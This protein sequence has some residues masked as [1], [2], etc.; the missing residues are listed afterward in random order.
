MLH[1]SSMEKERPISIPLPLGSLDDSEKEVA[2]HDS[3]SSRRPRTPSMILRNSP[4]FP[5]D[6]DTSENSIPR[7]DSSVLLTAEVIGTAEEDTLSPL[8]DE[9]QT[10]RIRPSDGSIHE[11]VVDLIGSEER[12]VSSLKILLGSLLNP[13]LTISLPQIT[14]NSLRELIH[15]IEVILQYNQFFLSSLRE[16]FFKDPTKPNV[17]PAFLG[18]TVFFNSYSTYIINFDDTAFLVTE[19]RKI[20]DCI[21][22]LSE[23]ERSKA[24]ENRELMSFLIMPVQRIT[25]YE[26]FL[27]RLIKKCAEEDDSK[28]IKQLSKALEQVKSVVQA[29]DKKTKESESKAKVIKMG[30]KLIGF[31][32][33]LTKSTS[34]SRAGRLFIFE[35]FLEREKRLRFCI[36]FND[37][38]IETEQI[39]GKYKVKS[40]FLTSQMVL[41]P[42]KDKQ[43]LSLGYLGKVLQFQC[44]SEV[45]RDLWRSSLKPVIAAYAKIQNFF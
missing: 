45:E 21:R 6:H 36:V 5:L 2:S 43:I 41:I 9:E 31:V 37:I 28:L 26:L 44:V 23:I 29:L 12:Y 32:D 15:S 20:P 4:S 39:E 18:I 30:Q 3:P 42:E 38:F 8:P 17:G 19:L 16:A 35:G 22:L 10:E 7:S 33:P 27:T 34:L 14:E 1:I 11:I 24:A 40:I 13:L 25:R